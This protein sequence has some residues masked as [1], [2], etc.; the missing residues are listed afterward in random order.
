[1]IRV[2]QDDYAYAAGR[3]RAR[4]IKLLDKSRFDR[5]LESPDA[6][7]AYKVLAEAEYGMGSES[8]KNVLEFDALLA[9]EMRKTYAFL[10]EIA[11]DKEVIKAFKGD[12]ISSM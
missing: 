9:D 2:N 11:P 8:T 5:M 6:E 7:E 1:M 10:S 4:E 3:I 12:M